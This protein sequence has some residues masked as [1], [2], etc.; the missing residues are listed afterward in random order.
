MTTRRRAR[1]GHDH[2]RPAPSTRCCRRSRSPASTCR[3]TPLGRPVSDLLGGAVRDAVPFSA[4]LFYKWAAHPGAE[5]DGWGE[6][7][8]PARHRRAGAADDRRV[9]LHRDQTQGR[10]VRRPRRRSPPS[11]RLRAA[12][13]DHPL[14]LDPNAAWTPE[15][16]M[17]VA[18]EL[19][20][21]LEY[22]EDP[23]PASTAWPRS[24]GS[25]RCRW[26]P[27]CASWRSTSSPPPSRNVGRR[28][29]LRSPL[30][31]WPAAVA[32]AR[33]HLRHVRPRAV[34]ALQLAPGHQPRRHGAP[35]G[36]DARTSPTP[37]TRTGRG[38]PRTSSSPARCGSSTARC[39][40]R[41]TPGLGVELDED[42]SPRCTS[43]ICA[44]ASA[45]ATTPATCAASTRRSGRA[46]RAGDRRGSTLMH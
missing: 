33:R 42:A 36:R 38:R 9:R 28:R 20:G 32:A 15:T 21:V 4:Y 18:P 16:S 24:R 5:P 13:P 19:A 43:S 34:H 45:T 30:L 26:P 23:T 14:R 17:K 37:A 27:T 44:A 12:F 10:R 29:A 39:R 8:D 2:R 41:P 35:G 40:Y 25:R 46:A 6:A 31:G 7:L 11:R 22:L 1:R 3:A